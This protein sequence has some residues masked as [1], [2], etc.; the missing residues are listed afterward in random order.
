MK[1]NSR[2]Q[3]SNTYMPGYNEA[4]ALQR[5]LVHIDE[6]MARQLPLLDDDSAKIDTE[7]F[8]ITVNGCSVAFYLGGPQTDALYSFVK[9][10]ADENMYDVDIDARTVIGW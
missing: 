6:A 3:T 8:T 2:Q 7:Q 1:N 9:H 4:F 10:I 5:L